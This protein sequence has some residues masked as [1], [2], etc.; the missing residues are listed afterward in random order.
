MTRI[1]SVSHGILG[2][3]RGLAGAR[4]ATPFPSTRLENAVVWLMRRRLA[5]CGANGDGD[6]AP[7]VAPGGAVRQMQDDATD[8]PFHPHGQLQQPLA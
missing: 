2:R 8:R 4:A 3:H 7:G 1:S 5:R 6:A